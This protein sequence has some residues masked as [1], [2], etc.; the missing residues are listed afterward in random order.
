MFNLD[1][2]SFLLGYVLYAAAF[3][4][5]TQLGKWAARRTGR[6]KVYDNFTHID[7]IPPPTNGETFVAI[8]HTE[9]EGV[10]WVARVNWDAPSSQWLYRF[11][12]ESFNESF[13]Y[14]KK[15]DE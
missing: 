7:F 8:S 5:T 6:K 11:T 14:W 3:Y 12:E 1:I 15:D 4:I 10:R 13:N 9:A 2:I